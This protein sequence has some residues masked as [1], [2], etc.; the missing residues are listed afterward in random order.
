MAQQ[1]SDQAFLRTA[2]KLLCLKNGIDAHHLKFSIAAFENYQH[3]SPKWRPNCLAASVFV[4]Q[5]TQME[6]NHAVAQAREALRSL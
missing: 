4:L 6:D 3:V 5:G 1:H 2:Q